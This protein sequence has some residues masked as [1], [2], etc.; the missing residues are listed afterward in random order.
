MSGLSPLKGKLLT[1]IEKAMRDLFAHHGMS[2]DG[3]ENM[4]IVLMDHE[5]NPNIII[6]FGAVSNPGDKQAINNA[7]E[8]LLHN[9]ERKSGKTGT[10]GGAMVITPPPFVLSLAATTVE[11]FVKGVNAALPQTVSKIAFD[12]GSSRMR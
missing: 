6:D 9:P 11:D 8:A 3:L 12:P 10:F 5:K 2:N 1:D 7:T 4:E